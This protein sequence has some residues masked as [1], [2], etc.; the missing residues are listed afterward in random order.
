ISFR[1]Q[2]LPWPHGERPLGALAET[3][4]S[5][6]ATLAPK[7]A[8]SPPQLPEL[9]VSPGLRRAL[10][11]L[12]DGHLLLSASPQSSQ[13][14]GHRTLLYGHAILLRHSHSAMYLSCLTTSR[15]LTDKLA[16]DVGLQEDASGE[17]CWWIIHPASKQR[18]EGEKV[19][20]G[21][22]LILV[23]VS[24]E[25]YLPELLGSLHHWPSPEQGEEERRVVNYEG[26]GVCTH[27]RS[28]WRLEPLRISWS[29]SYMRWGQQ[30]RVRHVTTG[31]Y[32]GLTEEKGLV[33]LD[34]EKANTKATAF[35]FRASKVRG[36]RV[37]VG[38]FPGAARGGW[39]NWGGSLFPLTCPTA[40]PAPPG[41]PA[42]PGG[43]TWT[44]HLSLTRCQHEESAGRR[45]Y[46][47]SPAAFYTNHSCRVG[48][49][50]GEKGGGKKMGK[51]GGPGGRVT[52]W[53]HWGEGG[54]TW[55]GTGGLGLKPRG[56]QGG[57]SG[58][59][60]LV[61]D[62]IDR[63]NLYSTAAHFA[64]FA[65][66]EA[67]ESWKEIVNLLYELLASLI[68]GN[69][70]NCAL[71]SN[72]LDWLVSKLDRLEASS[73][74]L[75]V[76]YC[77]LIESPEVLNII[78][79]NHIKSIISLL[80]KHGRNHK[81]LDV[82]CSL[83]VCNGVAVRSNQNLITE[84]LL[85]RRDLLLQTSLINYVTSMRPNIFLGTHEGST[86]YKKWY[87]ELIVD[88]VEP[89][90]T[91]QATHLRVGWA[92]TEG[93]SPYPGGGEGWGGNGV[94]DDLYSFGFDGLHLWSGTSAG[95]A[96]AHAAA[97]DVCE[98]CLTLSVPSMSFRHQR[99][100]R[101]G[102]FENF[103]VD[104]LFFPVSASPRASMSPGRGVLPPAG[105]GYAPCFEALLPEAGYAGGAHQGYRQDAGTRPQLL[106]HPALFH[107]RREGMWDLSPG[108]GGRAGG[109]VGE[110][111]PPHC[112]PPHRTLLALGCHVGMAD[113]KAE[114]N[115]KKTK[116]PK[117]Y[118][119][120][121]G[122]KPAPLDLAHVN[123]T[124]AQNTLVDK[125]AENGH[126]VWARDRVSQG[127]T[128][129]IVQV[130]GCGWGLGRGLLGGQAEGPG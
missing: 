120:S 71:F 96:Q 112:C 2:C 17:A 59:I 46:L 35:C 20:V 38:A 29:G 119:M 52:P 9:M 16:F 87:Y 44:T 94:G 68:R 102:M 121:N 1:R 11:S 27:A 91:A 130:G 84:N 42:H 74:I 79:E 125:L 128:Y 90:V 10:S 39:Q 45:I 65:G 32:L 105:A 78:Q 107:T 36:G 82:L 95:S 23:S 92:I 115:L 75:E 66:E 85:P 117:T 48:E 89:F 109:S 127:W 15:S 8:L 77:V 101:A 61:L 14:G 73:G 41:H 67:A 62:C 34:A 56:T 21:D 58:M 40:L 116:L 3:A 100:P 57:L 22:D 53:G 88:Y 28:L 70:S 103:N 63:L 124:P 12:A 69:R 5:R 13:G 97:D 76:L 25:R 18:S 111:T 122:Y 106:A 6:L 81:V 83:C 49:G 86:Q 129:S 99:L 113:E 126:N 7:G 72:N 104:G 80:D 110:L 33:V 19:R 31:R 30:F 64:E 24:S 54:Q 51:P 47:Q 108:G 43:A 26:G 37:A 114:E 50:G 93:Y 118:M 123:L 4:G 98:R 55:R 60:T